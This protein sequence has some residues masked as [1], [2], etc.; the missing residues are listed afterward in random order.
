LISLSKMA[1]LPVCFCAMAVF[2]SQ[3][4]LVSAQ[5]SHQD[6]AHDSQFVFDTASIHLDAPNGMGG[7]TSISFQSDRY[8][9]SHVDLRTVLKEASDD[10]FT[11]VQKP[12]LPSSGRIDPSFPQLSAAPHPRINPNQPCA[13]CYLHSYSVPTIIASPSSAQYSVRFL[14]IPFARYKARSAA[15]INS[16]DEI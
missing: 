5:D 14:P 15:R 16:I 11:A 2:H 8:Q 1:A 9:A 12:S 7:M 3:S 13:I 4:L 6:S 10:L